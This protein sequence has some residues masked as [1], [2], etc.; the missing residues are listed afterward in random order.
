M[1]C[2]EL[3]NV[4]ANEDIIAGEDCV[5]GTIQSTAE[6]FT[7]FVPVKVRVTAEGPHEGV[8]GK[9]VV[10]AETLVIEGGV[11]VNGTGAGQVMTC[12]GTQGAMLNADKFAV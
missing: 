12:V 5:A 1:S 3:T 7:K 8:E 4:V 2:V 6:P 9:E 10:E 11:I